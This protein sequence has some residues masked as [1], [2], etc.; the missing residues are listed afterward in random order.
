VAA[1]WAATPRP[2]RM[3]QVGEV[4][5]KFRLQTPGVAAPK[6]VV[7]QLRVTT[8]FFFFNKK[9]KLFHNIDI[10]ILTNFIKNNICYY[11][12]VVD[13]YLTKSVKYFN[14]I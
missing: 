3:R 9:Q 8:Y 2:S 4:D 12:I 6:G 13:V 10:T 14:R 11:F 1:D 7:A 5:V